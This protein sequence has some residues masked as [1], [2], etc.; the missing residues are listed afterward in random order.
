MTSIRPFSAFAA[1]VFIPTSIMVLDKCL[2]NEINSQFISIVTIYGLCCL[3]LFFLWCCYGPIIKDILNRRERMAENLAYDL[4]N[5][6]L[7]EPFIPED[8]I[9]NR[10]HKKCRGETGNG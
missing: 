2:G 4:R 5:L 7:N 8:L 1:V 10:N 6:K 3:L 9:Q